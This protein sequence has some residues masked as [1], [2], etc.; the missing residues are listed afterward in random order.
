MN[1]SM[2]PTRLENQIHSLEAK[3]LNVTQQKKRSAVQLQHNSRQENESVY[4]YTP[5]SLWSNLWYGLGMF[6]VAV[7]PP[8]V[9]GV[10][11]RG[12][13]IGYMAALVTIYTLVCIAAIARVMRPMK[14]PA[15]KR[16]TKLYRQQ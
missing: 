9:P 15:R 6:V 13:I 7:I 10:S 12:L 3:P 8:F 1:K 4:E 2:I 16:Y 14:A 11:T 5:D